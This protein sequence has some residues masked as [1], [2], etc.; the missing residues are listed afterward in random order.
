M[1]SVGPAT[2]SSTRDDSADAGPG[3]ASTSDTPLDRISFAVKLHTTTLSRT[4]L[5]AGF[6]ITRARRQ[7]RHIEISCEREGMFGVTIPYLLVVCE[8][9][10][11]PKG[12]LPNIRRS[13]ARAGGVVVLVAQESGPEWLSWPEF[14]AALGGAVP[15]WRALGA[16]YAAILRAVA[17][18]E[19]PAGMTGEA[20][21]IFEEAVA[22]GLEFLFGRRVRRMGGNR[23]GQ[24]VSDIIALSPDERVLV[25]DAKASGKTYDVTWPKLRPLVEYVKAQKAR[26]KGQLDVGG[27]VIVAAEFK[28]PKTG[29]MDLH[30]E[31]FSDTQVPLTFVDVEV[32]LTLVSRMTDR[33]DLRT[34]VAWAKLFCRGGRLTAVHVQRELDAA[35]AER[36]AR[37]APVP[38]A[39]R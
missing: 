34:A 36:L 16:D 24:R 31:F 18:T 11:P 5:A 9:D 12:D 6:T 2:A 32:L 7:P 30:G 39:K 14:L 13:A 20:W 15:T 23:R 1:P 22:D 25:V 28:Q 8:D 19:L 10:E 26:Q 35:D 21:Q 29:L 17:K 33:P 37:G 3:A 38:T 4:L 27:A